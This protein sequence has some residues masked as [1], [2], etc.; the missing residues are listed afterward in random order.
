MTM[1]ELVMKTLQPDLLDLRRQ[2][3]EETQCLDH[4]NAPEIL[5]ETFADVVVNT[6]V[7]DIACILEYWQCYLHVSE[8]G[9]RTGIRMLHH[10]E[11]AIPSTFQRMLKEARSNLWLTAYKRR[12]Y[13][14]VESN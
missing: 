11:S 10:L 4:A 9:I 12:G 3:I 5:S 7:N 8:P 1:R 13:K 6:L 2:L 14:H